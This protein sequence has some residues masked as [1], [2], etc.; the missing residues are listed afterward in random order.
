LGGVLAVHVSQGLFILVKDGDE[1]VVRLVGEL[2]LTTADELRQAIGALLSRHSC[3]VLLDLSDLHFCDVE[4]ARALVWSSSLVGEHDHRM[5]VVGA[6]ASVRA[7]LAVSF[8]DQ[9][10][11]VESPEESA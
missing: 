11:D 6:R 10:V 5:R 2:D 3:D 4:G 8:A 1:S 9:L 7:T